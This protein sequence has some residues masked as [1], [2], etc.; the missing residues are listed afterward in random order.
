MKNKPLLFALGL[1]LTIVN[2]PT[3]AG[4][5]STIKAVSA[6]GAL[7]IGSF[8]GLAVYEANRINPNG[9]S[10][11][12]NTFGSYVREREAKTGIKLNIFTRTIAAFVLYNRYT[13][14]GGWND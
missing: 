6:V 7:G 4:F 1:T 13:S 12:L 10:S 8:G 3:N 11:A 9:S 14:G 5:L 2:L